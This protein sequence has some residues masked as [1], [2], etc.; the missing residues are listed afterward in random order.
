MFIL[1]RFGHVFSLVFELVLEGTLP[2]AG[3]RGVCVGV[4]DG[5]LALKLVDKLS[6]PLLRRFFLSSLDIVAMGVRERIESKRLV[7]VLLQVVVHL[8]F[9]HAHL[10]VLTVFG[11]LRRFLLAL[12][13]P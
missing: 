5:S 3:D 6:S 8:L 10:D 2:S 9:G 13:L 12:N 11:L 1:L 7:I 4:L